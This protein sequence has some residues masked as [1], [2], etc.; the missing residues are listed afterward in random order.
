MHI[1]LHNLFLLLGNLYS[2]KCI[3]PKVYLISSILGEWHFVYCP[4]ERLGNGVREESVLSEQSLD[5][6]FKAL[7]VHA[8]LQTSDTITH[9]NSQVI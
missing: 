6:W 2:Q 7:S 4:I 3:P 1:V 8:D 5:R 9:W